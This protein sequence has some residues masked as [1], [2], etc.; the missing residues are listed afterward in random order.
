MQG[1]ELT[2]LDADP[3]YADEVLALFQGCL[4]GHNHAVCGEPSR[5]GA[6]PRMQDLKECLGVLVVHRQGKVLGALGI[7][8]YSEEQVTLWGPVVHRA[9]I[10]MDIGSFLFT[11]A[12]QAIADGGYESVRISVD[13]RNRSA[14]SFL[15]GKG[16]S[17]WKDN[18]IYERKLL[19]ELPDNPG[20]VAVARPDDLRDVAVIL[21]AGFP[22]SSHCD[23]PLETREHAGYRH[24]LM[25]DCGVIVG[26]AAVKVT[27]G[28]SWM[29]L[30]SI[31]P[32]YRGKGYGRKL[33]SG[34]LHNEM[35]L[36]VTRLGL[37]VLADNRAAIAIYEGVGF[38]RQWTATIMT[39]PV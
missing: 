31:R 38:R 27:P 4:P 14:R 11:Q 16:M 24:H 5:M 2:D 12:K 28:R 33:L 29:S 1:F 26:A 8:P 23:E 10:R 7:C 36:G 32:D 19:E 37:E 13:I 25:Q 3:Q 17:P 21:E 34:I 15:L 6:K 35:S 18:C 30:F 9:Y 22:E 39:G 20:G